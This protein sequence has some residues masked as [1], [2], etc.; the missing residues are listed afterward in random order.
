MAG[1]AGGT[2]LFVWGDNAF[3]KLGVG[4]ICADLKPTRLGYQFP[5][6]CTALAASGRST[7]VVTESGELFLWGDVYDGTKGTVRYTPQRV[8]FPPRT[9]VRSISMGQ[10]HIMALDAAGHLYTWGM[11]LDGRLGHGD[12]GNRDSPT[13]VT[14]LEE[15][16]VAV[17]AIAAGA[18]HCLAAD[19]EGTVWS[20]G[21]GLAGA[22][23][24]GN[25]ENCLV[26]A[27]IDTASLMPT[28]ILDGA[29][30]EDGGGGSAGRQVRC[31][32]AS[33]Q[34]S[35]AVTVDGRLFTWGLGC[36]YA[37]GLGTMDNA[38]VPSEVQ[39]LRYARIVSAALGPR[40]GAAIGADG[41]LYTW[42]S[43]T[44]GRLGHGD[45]GVTHRLPSAVSYF[46]G[47]R[48]KQVSIE[49]SSAGS[50]SAYY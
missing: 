30:G 13:V 20:W 14:G 6:R 10:A 38:H 33:T 46:D 36:Y 1:A 39:T 49:N 32:V 5:S 21:C 15:A 48:V 50:V 24:L 29:T 22:L 35:A 42:G 18:S 40:H 28:E 8:N 12:A 34:M 4:D 26:P 23:G 27:P 17:M 9:T 44:H 47:R 2:A 7:G 41:V 45:S 43:G 19:A 3:G 37:L 25:E 16:G 11:G 31:L